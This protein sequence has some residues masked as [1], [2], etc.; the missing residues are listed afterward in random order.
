MKIVLVKGNENSGKSTLLMNFI[1]LLIDD[2]F[3]LIM[4]N[5]VG[6]REYDVS[7]LLRKGDFTV[8]VHC[9]ADDNARID[10]LER[11]LKYTKNVD[12]VVTACRYKGKCCERVQNLLQGFEEPIDLEEPI[13]MKDSASDIIRAIGEKNLE[14]REK[15]QMLVLEKMKELKALQDEAQKQAMEECDMI[16]EKY[17]NN[18]C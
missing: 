6:G 2:G 17:A 4:K 15:V 7:V 9:A 12:L 10:E 5:I 1:K 16:E 13:D 8:L 11:F 3:E 14:L 18:A